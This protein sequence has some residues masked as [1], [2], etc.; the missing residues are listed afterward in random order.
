MTWPPGTPHPQQPSAAATIGLHHI[1]H[2]TI[3]IATAVGHLQRHHHDTHKRLDKIERQQ[4]QPNPGAGS[5]S[6]WR[7]RGSQRQK[8]VSR[9][10]KL[11]HMMLRIAELLIKVLPGAAV[12]GGL[13]W[14]HLWPAIS[15]WLG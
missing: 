1:W 9:R 3:Q 5:G 14:K 8:E 13:A 15:R 11:A 12:L 4:L 6:A 7:V 10:L 2:A